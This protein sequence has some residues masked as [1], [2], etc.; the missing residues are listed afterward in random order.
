MPTPMPKE[1]EIERKWFVLDAEGQ[2]LGRLASRVASILR[3]K[4]K[5]NFVPHLDVGD[6]VVVVNAER[7][8]LDRKST[9]LNSS[10]SQISYAVFCLKK[11]NQK[12]FNSLRAQASSNRGR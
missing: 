3:G 2:V 12:K 5:T 8:H 1:S 9:R 7:V 4:H 11:K 6:H 10:H